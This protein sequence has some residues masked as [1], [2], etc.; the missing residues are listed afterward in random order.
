MVNLKPNPFIQCEKDEK[1]GGRGVWDANVFG[2]A[3]HKYYFKNYKYQNKK[4]TLA[5][6]KY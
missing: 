5:Q 3:N 1:R 2:F 6:N 4:T